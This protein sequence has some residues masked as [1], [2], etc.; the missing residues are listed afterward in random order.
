LIAHRDIDDQGYP[1]DTDALLLSTRIRSLP[2]WIND[3]R[4]AGKRREWHRWGKEAGLTDSDMTYVLDELDYYACVGK[5]EIGI[6]AGCFD[7]VWIAKALVDNDL[8]TKLDQQLDGFKKL[9]LRQSRRKHTATLASVDGRGGS[10]LNVIGTPGDMLDYDI[11][12]VLQ[13]AQI[14]SLEDAIKYIGHGKRLSSTKQ[15]ENAY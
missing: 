12:R 11:T 5:P 6:E 1:M 3:R 10:V 2:D 7:M 14:R 9:T 13:D 8:Y 4:S 15:W